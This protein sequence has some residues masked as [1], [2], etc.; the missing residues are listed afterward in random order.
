M[1]KFLCLY[2]LRLVAA[3]NGLCGMHKCTKRVGAKIYVYLRADVLHLSIHD[4]RNG[5]LCEGVAVTAKPRT[6]SGIISPRAN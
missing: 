6:D 4:T 5:A 2:R 3:V 1:V